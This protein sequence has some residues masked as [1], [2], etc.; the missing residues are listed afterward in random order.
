MKRLN[1]LLPLLSLISLGAH[2]EIKGEEAAKLTA[3]PEV[4]PP[5]ERKHNTKVVVKLEVI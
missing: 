4:P 1:A 2:A 3:P 5:I